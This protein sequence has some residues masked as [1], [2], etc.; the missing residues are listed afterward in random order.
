MALYL[1]LNV[2]VTLDIMHNLENHNHTVV[3][4]VVNNG[5]EKIVRP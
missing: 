3:M 1:V 4:D 5:M 2:V